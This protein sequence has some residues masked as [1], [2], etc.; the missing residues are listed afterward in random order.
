MEVLLLITMGLNFHFRVDTKPECPCF[1]V[2]S[3]APHSH[4]KSFVALSQ[5]AMG[6]VT[7]AM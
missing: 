7:S 4:L 5:L 2:G 1:E 6:Q 3:S